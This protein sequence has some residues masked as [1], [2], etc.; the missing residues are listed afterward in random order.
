MRAYRYL[1]FITALFVTVLLVSNIASTKF[2]VFGPFTF[3][4]GSLLFPLSY[5]FGD[6][7]TEV[8]GYRQSRRVIWTGFLCLALMALTLGV[9]DA[10]PPASDWTLQAAF[11]ALLGQ[12]PRIVFASLVAYWAGEFVNSYTLAK[13]KL[14]TQGRFLWVR[15]LGSTLLGEGVDTIAFVGV[16]FL[17]AWPAALL[18][19]VF[20]SNYVFK[21][22]VEALFT[23]LT[24]QIVNFLKRA[25]NEDYYDRNTNFNPLAVRD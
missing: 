4:G 16:A 15:T 21:V 3:D 23:P 18:W 7:L 9:V 13:M 22:G 11:H 1:T 19:Q 17:G 14:W 20:I 24:Y 5:I 25:E 6:I 12:T 2:L 10:L 8:Y